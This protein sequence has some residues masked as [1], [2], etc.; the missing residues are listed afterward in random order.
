[1]SR[2]AE[3]Y[4]I[5]RGRRHDRDHRNL[6]PLTVA[7]ALRA[8]PQTVFSTRGARILTI[9]FAAAVVSR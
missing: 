4:N 1:M 7:R 6:R 5:L 3:R 9:V 2:R 8:R